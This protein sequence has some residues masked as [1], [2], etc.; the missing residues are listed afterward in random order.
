MK[1]HGIKSQLFKTQHGANFVGFRVLP[2]QIRVRSDNLRRG[3]KRLNQ[4]LKQYEQGEIPWEVVERSLESWF[5]HLEHGD[6][7]KI[8]HNVSERVRNA[9]K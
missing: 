1:I 8:Q 9:R 3:R 7:W 5:A 6:T 4:Q 2:N